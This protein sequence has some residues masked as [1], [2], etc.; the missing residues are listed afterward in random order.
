MFP[1]PHHLLFISKKESRILIV[2]SDHAHVKCTKFN[3]GNNLLFRKISSLGHHAL[4][5][6]FILVYHHHIDFCVLNHEHFTSSNMWI[7]MWWKT[8]M[9]IPN[10]LKGNDVKM[11]RVVLSKVLCRRKQ[12]QIHVAS[13]AMLLRFQPGDVSTRRPNWFY[14][15][16]PLKV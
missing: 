14:L 2:K 6:W 12:W 1:L 11:Q 8:W 10:H 15:V 5:G 4:G 13:D 16:G 3:T 9:P 7:A